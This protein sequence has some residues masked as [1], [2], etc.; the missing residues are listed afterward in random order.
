MDGAGEIWKVGVVKEVV[1]ARR[2]TLTP[3][4]L[5]DLSVLPPSEAIIGDS[6]MI[7]PICSVFSAEH[8]ADQVT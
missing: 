1:V 2:S 6:E 8:M 7:Q 5:F 4:G 3:F